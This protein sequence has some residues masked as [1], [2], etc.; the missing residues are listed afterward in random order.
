MIHTKS[1]C[2]LV[3]EKNGRLPHKGTRD[4]DALLLPPTQSHTL[5][6]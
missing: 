1:T 3:E 2:R 5:Y 4:G 6:I